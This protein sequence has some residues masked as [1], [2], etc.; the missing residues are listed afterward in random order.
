[1]EPGL[2]NGKNLVGF[3]SFDVIYKSMLTGNSS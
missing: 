3:G 1:M 2:D